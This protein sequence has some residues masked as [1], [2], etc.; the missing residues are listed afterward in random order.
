MCSMC[1]KSNLTTTPD[2][3]FRFDAVPPLLPFYCLRHVFNLPCTTFRLKFG[4]C[5]RQHLSAPL[6]FCLRNSGY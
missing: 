5:R 2:V 4:Q 6:H 3:F 1:S